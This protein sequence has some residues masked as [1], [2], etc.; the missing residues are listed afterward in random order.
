MEPHREL[1]NSIEEFRPSFDSSPQEYFA[2]ALKFAKAFY[3]QE[4]DNIS[5]TKFNE[6]TPEF[7]FR[8]Y[9][10]VVHAT[11]FSAKA[12]GKFMPR[13]LEAYGDWKTLGKQRPD[14]AIER[15]RV[16]CNNPQ[17]ISAIHRMART[18]SDVVDSGSM[19]WED[20]REQALGST[21]K[22]TKLP[23]IGKVTCF[24]LARNIGLLDSVKPDLHFVRMAEHWGFGDSVSMC[25][26]MQ[27]DSDLPLGIVDLILWYAASTFGTLEIKKDG[28]R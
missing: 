21:E 6:V 19:T 16:V 25:K 7:F 23:Y 24:H 17:K 9:I 3:Q 4:I 27:G 12:V 2:K 11:G 26:A 28:A 10:W 8:E 20:Y 1:P 14:E 15:V 5:A 22:M 18:M 13:L